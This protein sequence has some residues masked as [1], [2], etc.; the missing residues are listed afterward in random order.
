MRRLRRAI[1]AHKR[2]QVFKPVIDQRYSSDEIVSH[3]DLRMKC[4]SSNRLPR[5]CTISMPGPRWS[6]S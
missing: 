4:K 5:F 1:I 3:N 6:A 2:V